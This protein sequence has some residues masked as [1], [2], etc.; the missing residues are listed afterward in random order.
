MTVC[1]RIRS[2]ARVISLSKKLTPMCSSRPR[3]QMGTGILQCWEGNRLAVQGGVAIRSPPKLQVWSLAQSL[4][5]RDGHSDLCNYR[6][7]PLP[8]FFYYDTK[9]R[10]IGTFVV[11]MERGE[12][13]RTTCTKIRRIRSFVM[14]ISKGC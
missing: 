11:S 1:V 8:F 4:R 2:A 7:S 3:C 6:P 10:T 12:V 5:K 9:W 13:N 14:K